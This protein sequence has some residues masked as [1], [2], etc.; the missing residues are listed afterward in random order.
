MDFAQQ[1]TDEV[2][3]DINYLFI[4]CFIAFETSLYVL[5]CH[6]YPIFLDAL[7]PAPHPSIPLTPS[8]QGEGLILTKSKGLHV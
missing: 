8:P 6:R 7:H 4:S 2:L 3:P 1:K 5:L